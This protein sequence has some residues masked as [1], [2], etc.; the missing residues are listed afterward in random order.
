MIYSKLLFPIQFLQNYRMY[1]NKYKMG[2]ERKKSNL[3][4]NCLL[5]IV[6]C[7]L[8][9]GFGVMLGDNL[10]MKFDFVNETGTFVLNKIL[11]E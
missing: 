9:I 6:Y 2:S 11:N 8:F 10:T 5:F 3:T 7:L 4:Y 1:Y